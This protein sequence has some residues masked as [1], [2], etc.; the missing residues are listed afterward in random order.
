MSRS[1]RRTG[2]R[3]AARAVPAIAVGR[4]PPEERA[5]KTLPIRILLVEDNPADARLVRE[6]LRG[7]DPRPVEIHHVDRLAEAVAR[8]RGEPTDL[9]LLDLSLP[10][11][12]GLG[13]LA[14][15]LQVAPGAPV[16][17]LTGL[18]DESLAEEAVRAG[19]QE[20]LV[21]GDINGHGLARVIRYAFERKRRENEQRRAEAELLLLHR[22]A[23][24]VGEA[25]DL[26]SALLLVL[27]EICL[28]TGW[29]TGE[30]WLPSEGGARLER[31]PVRTVAD[32]ALERFHTESGT[33][34][35]VPGEGLPGRVWQSGAPLWVPDTSACPDSDRRD[36]ARE[37]GLRAAMVIPVLARDEVAAVLAFY[38][39][40]AREQDERL[41]QL[42]A[43]AAAQ[44]GTL[45]RRRRLE[46]ELRR[47]EA[48]LRRLL[49]TANEGI[50]ILDAE[51]RVEYVN[52]R[53][54]GMLGYEVPEMHGRPS[55]DFLG[56]EVA[57]EG[58]ARLERRRRGESECAEA[59]LAR[60][61]GAELW[62]LTS[63]SPIRDELG[64]FRGSLVM[65]SDITDRRAAEDAERL[66]AEAGRVFASS[67]DH[68][69]TLR[70][71][72]GLLVPRLA[73]WCVIDVLDE[74]GEVQDVQVT[75][76]DPGKEALLRRML[77]RYPHHA[78]GESHPVWRV[79]HTGESAL[80]PG[81]PD[82]TLVGM[83][84]DDGHLDLL[85]RLEPWSSIVVPLPAGGRVLGALT[86][87]RSPG[88]RAFGER[89]L[90]LAEEPGR[91]AALAIENA[92]LYG[93][94]RRALHERDEV[95]G[96][97]VH[98]LRNPLSAISMTAS[99]LLDLSLSEDQRADRLGG[100]LRAVE[101]MNHLIQDLLDVSRIEAGRMRVEAEPLCVRTV[102]AG[103]RETL[104][105]AATGA[106]LRIETEVVGSIPPVRA[107]RQ[108]VLQ[109][110]SNLIGN[111]IKFTPAGGTIIVRAEPLGEKVLISV[112]DT[113]VGIAESQIPHLFDRFWQAHSASRG[114]AGLGLVIARGIVEAHGGR[115]WVE[116]SP[117]LGSTFSFTLPVAGEGEE[118]AAANRHEEAAVAL[119][120]PPAPRRPL[121]V[122]L[123]DDHPI[124]LRSVE[125]ILRNDGAFE[126]VATAATGEEAV[127]QARA[128]RPDV[129]LMDL[130]MPGMG[131]IEAIRQI[132]GA[133]PE[134]R[135]IALTANPEEESLVP[136]L[137]AGA[138]G[139]VLKTAPPEALVGAMRAALRDG[140]R[141][142][143]AGSRLLLDRY[144]ELKRERE[145]DPTSR[146]TDQERR[147][148]AL[149]AEGYTSAEI[150]RRLF[151]S[152][153]TVDSYRSRLMRKLDLHG[154]A[155]VVRLALR[156]G[157]LA[158]DP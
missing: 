147:L 14:A 13:T 136:A 112:S 139:Y 18:R 19:A 87:T 118:A 27:E 127:E 61:D 132:V 130:S 78:A 133:D 22:L 28:A 92:R 69:E 74:S 34:A 142:G 84:R 68:Q 93:E 89:E 62:A 1:S 119:P 135:A 124:L 35:F 51:D 140:V 86:L 102:V 32:G 115:I 24:A 111:A 75:A 44:L 113:G 48:K 23:L 36:L 129:A 52:A 98:D 125:E 49:N 120:D 8:L 10:D 81:I 46:R 21:K 26:E 3:H 148:L 106:G 60:K 7:S 25:E 54:A 82:E 71:V 123:A 45:V 153:T 95:L 38:H 70:A 80:L 53:L 15:V 101:Q 20:Y 103:A 77:D 97:V 64:E 155:E 138:S 50:W 72:G 6:L 141:V 131:G 43:T 121:R 65:V 37:V 85:R 9:V 96:F 17:V 29:A 143:T 12:V 40:Q 88:G 146:L 30:S 128:L 105:D 149:T 67:L 2:S 126:V 158:P 91:R 104:E 144:R 33:L 116:S 100:I 56:E 134:I 107:D 108:R 41:V 47:S 117:G 83:A 58:E 5:T 57:T 122:L 150:G 137:E 151:L 55:T 76:A 73:D 157:L 110:L 63:E 11:S 94:A 99:L 42:V 114:G 154:R 90:A 16:V 59:C 145:E 156:T 152:P 31:G 109:V 4:S 39:T 66:L 79:L